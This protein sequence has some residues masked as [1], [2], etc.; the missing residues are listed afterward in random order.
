MEADTDYMNKMSI[1]LENGMGFVVSNWGGD[2]SW[3]WKDRCSG[4]CNWPKLSV[5]NISIKT[6][7]APPT[8]PTPTPY[9][10]SEF[11]FGDAC[12]TGTSDD[13]AVQTS[14][15]SDATHCRWSWS[16]TD[17]QKWDGKTAH[18]RC[19]GA[20]VIDPKDFDFGDPCDSKSSDDCGV[21]NCPSVDHCRWSWSKTDPE[22]WSG[23][24]AHCRCDEN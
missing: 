8:P 20:S 18:C 13:C 5:S 16:L 17:P 11:A 3:L 23:K 21:M 10:P 22:K 19:D 15:C 12:A 24:T 4:D 2:A 14:F 1:D 9:D 6:G 7:L